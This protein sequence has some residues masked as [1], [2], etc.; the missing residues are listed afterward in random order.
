M[1]AKLLVLYAFTPIFEDA[2][3]TLTTLSIDRD[4]IFIT[5]MG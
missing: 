2:T 3:E 1:I 5:P 4:V